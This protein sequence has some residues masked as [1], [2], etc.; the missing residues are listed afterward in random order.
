MIGKEIQREKKK[1]NRE[2]KGVGKEERW[3][4]KGERE[5][6]RKREKEEG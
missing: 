3:G 1:E 6:L 5:T 4:K 2:T